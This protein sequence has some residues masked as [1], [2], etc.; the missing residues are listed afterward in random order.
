MKQSA[1]EAVSLWLA[2]N[3]EDVPPFEAL[4]ARQDV[5]VMTRQAQDAVLMPADAGAW[6][7]ALRAAFAAR[8]A[9][10]NDN[11]YLGALY[12]QAAAG[13]D[14]ADLAQAGFVPAD[15][16][17]QKVVAFM[18]KV[19]NKTKD[20]SADDIVV[21]QQAGIADADIVRLCE[22]NA[23]LAYQIRVASGLAS[24]AEA[25]GEQN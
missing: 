10:A 8:I 3:V 14:Y 17:Q 15:A 18:D 5:F 9:A 16:V 19:A 1:L 6:P 2:G 22:L 20:V 21:L 7:Y 24:L 11:P 13:S 23:F 25:D 4:A 12:G